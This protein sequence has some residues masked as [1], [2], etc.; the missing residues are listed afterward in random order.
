MT[1]PLN[2]LR[3]QGSPCASVDKEQVRQSL[4]GVFLSPLTAW[5]AFC[6]S[7]ERGSTCSVLAFLPFPRLAPDGTTEQ[8]SLV[9]CITL[10]WA[11]CCSALHS[12]FH[13]HNQ[14]SMPRRH[15][16]CQV[17]KE[18]AQCCSSTAQET[19]GDISE[20]EV[21]T[22]PWYRQFGEELP[23]A[24]LENEDEKNVCYW[25]FW[26]CTV[27]WIPG[28][29]LICRR[30]AETISQCLSLFLLSSPILYYS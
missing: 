11:H 18:A 27:R 30:T 16:L 7:T 10:S 5:E 14:C 15:G 8:K 13:G 20:R 17:S 2:G 1:Q 26:V 19:A 9:W 29:R 12:P 24:H 22:T 4:C 21:S 25:K 6:T 23:W 28:R 3:Y